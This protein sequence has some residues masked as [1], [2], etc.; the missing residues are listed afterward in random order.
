LT[1]Y[2]LCCLI[3]PHLDFVDSRTKRLDPMTGYRAKD[4][5]SIPTRAKNGPRFGLKMIL[6]LE[7]FDYAYFPRESQGFLVALTDAA[8]QP[9]INQDGFYLSPGEDQRGN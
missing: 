7:S 1:D 3:V 4:F 5:L 9:V 6:D 2:G 8:D